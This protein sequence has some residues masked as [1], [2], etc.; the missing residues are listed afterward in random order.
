MD[1]VH[2]HLILNHIPAI[3]LLIATALLITALLRK[4]DELMKV[5]LVL[6]VFLAL[7]SIPVFMTG[8]PSEEEV[9]HLPQVSH[10][11]IEKHEDAAAISLGVVEILGVSSLAGL[12]LFRGA[13]IPKWFQLVILVLCI[14][15]TGLMG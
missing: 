7:I 6:F 4:N 1:P 10:S 2:I 3:G 8:E 9:E 5:V 12:F 14:V 11:L 13:R 15:S